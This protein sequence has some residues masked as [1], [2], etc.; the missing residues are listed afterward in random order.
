M[1][2]LGITMSE[3][4]HLPVVDQPR[5]PFKDEEKASDTEKSGVE[6]EGRIDWKIA[7]AFNANRYPLS[8][9][10]Q[11]FKKD[12][13]EA[14]R[15]YEKG[16]KKPLEA[17]KE[18]LPTV[19]HP[20]LELFTDFDLTREQELKTFGP[21]LACVQVTKGCRHQCEH[22]AIDARKKVEF[23]PFAAVLKINEEVKKNIGEFPKMFEEWK[24]LF[25][26]CLNNG[27][28]NKEWEE[29]KTQPVRW[30][31]PDDEYGI[32][33]YFYV[34][35]SADPLDSKRFDKEMA[36]LYEKAHRIYESI[37]PEI[38]EQEEYL[39]RTG[40]L[41][42]YPE[43]EFLE[44]NLTIGGSDDLKEKP[45]HLTHYYDNDPFDYRD[46]TF[47]HEDGTPADYGDVFIVS[48]PNSGSIEIT[49][50]G[51]PQDDVTA[52]RAAE[53]IVK[54]IISF[55]PARRDTV[56]VS[57]HPFER[58]TSKG[59]SKKYREDVENTLRTLSVV[60][61]QPVVINSDDADEQSRF[62]REILLPL[63][64]DI[65]DIISIAEKLRAAKDERASLSHFSGRAKKDG[66]DNGNDV[67]ACMEGIH[68]SPDGHIAEQGENCADISHPEKETRP[69]PLGYRLYTLEPKKRKE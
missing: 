21:D 41:K 69:Q 13:Q 43:S 10:G 33:R 56:R 32:F 37:H 11:K 30:L 68:I 52:Q 46:T 6:S 47:L 9:E 44:V 7:R 57:I 65:G 12:V 53:K 8:E 25:V 67:M 29:L 16:D 58:G 27:S 2:S 51:W 66:L 48:M 34:S 19:E 14:L 60:G 59:D 23:M 18:R 24:R 15:R 1:V 26:K 42:K 5:N 38:A 39:I 36:I 4:F 55:G 22:C 3:R 62:V 40:L 20:H 28:M 50:A 61:P 45:A 49:T 64:E 35:P 63:S 17:L 54:A 31:D